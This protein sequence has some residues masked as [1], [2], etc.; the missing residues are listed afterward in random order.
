MRPTAHQDLLTLVWSGS[1]L[2]RWW[3]RWQQRLWHAIQ[4]PQRHSALLAAWHQE[5]QTWRAAPL[6]LAA[7]G[8]LA[9]LLAYGLTLWALYRWPAPLE[10]MAMVVV[11][12]C[13]VVGWHASVSWETLLKTSWVAQRLLRRGT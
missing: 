1:Q 13:V 9:W 6:W 7:R 8:G 11:G 4:P 5:R 2:G 10:G 12:G 3:H